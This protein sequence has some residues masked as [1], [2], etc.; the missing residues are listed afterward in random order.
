MSP[1]A[2]ATCLRAI[3]HIANFEDAGSSQILLRMGPQ[4][5][6]NRS[7]VR[8]NKLDH[9]EDHGD[10]KGHVPGGVERDQG[11]RRSGLACTSALSLGFAPTMRERKPTKE[12]ERPLVM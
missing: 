12:E 3:G 7:H 4:E 2:A 5:G 6:A 10:E 1:L 8:S 11:P 9:K